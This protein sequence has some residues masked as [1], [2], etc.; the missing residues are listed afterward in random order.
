MHVVY[1]EIFP[2]SKSGTTT[3][4][5]SDYEVLHQIEKSLHEILK[6][7]HISRVDLENLAWRVERYNEAECNVR[8]EIERGW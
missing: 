8:T 2:A 5:H 3:I 7:K 1:L 6:E 4:I